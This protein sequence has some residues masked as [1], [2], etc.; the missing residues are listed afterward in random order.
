MRVNFSRL[1]KSEI[2][3]KFGDLGW[4]VAVERLSEEYDVD[5]V[6]IQLSK[7][8]WFNEDGKGIHF[9]TWVTHKEIEKRSLKFVMHVLHHKFFP[10]T[11]KKPWDLILPFIEDQEVISH[12]ESWK[13]FNMGRTHPIKGQRRFKDSTTDLIISEFGTFLKLGS[14]VDSI[15]KRILI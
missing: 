15:L 13:G 3:E 1:I 9:E 8:N 2:E 12:V 4:I 5:G 11:E 14:K 7:T 10:G 6:G